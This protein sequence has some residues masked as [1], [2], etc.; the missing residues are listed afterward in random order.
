MIIYRF[1]AARYKEDISGNGAKLFG[2]RWNS[3]GLPVLYASNHIS[4]SVLELL[5]H[6]KNYTSF[7]D[8]FLMS[9]SIPEGIIP[10]VATAEKL[11][12]G[13]SNSIAYTRWIGDQF[14]QVNRSLILQVPSAIIPQEHNFLVNPL[15]SDFKKIKIAATELFELDKRLLHQ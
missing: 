6:N 13:W 7:Q 5:V 11:K 12:A 10:V 15:H 1:T 3:K 9:I 2:G 4:L 14:L 8:P